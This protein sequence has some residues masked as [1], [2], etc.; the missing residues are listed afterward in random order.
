MEHILI[1]VSVGL[2]GVFAGAS[3][4]QSMKQLPARRR[5][6]FVVYSAHSRAADEDRGLAWYVILGVGAAI[7]AVAAATTTCF[8][9]PSAPWTTLLGMAGALSVI[10]TFATARVTPTNFGRRHN[11]EEAELHQLFET[12]ARR[13]NLRSIVQLLALLASLGALAYKLG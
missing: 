7:A 13:Q 6:G 9:D 4:D 5:I 3:L 8:E 1:I 12:F 11:V 2:N 10:Q